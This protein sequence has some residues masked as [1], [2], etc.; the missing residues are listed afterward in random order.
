MQSNETA[1]MSLSGALIL[2]QAVLDDNAAL[3]QL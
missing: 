1:E 2:G 3:S